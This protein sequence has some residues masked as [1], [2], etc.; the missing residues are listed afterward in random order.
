M[1]SYRVQSKTLADWHYHTGYP[2]EPLSHIITGYH[3]PHRGN[4]CRG[5][6]R[7]A[8]AHCLPGLRAFSWLWEACIDR[9]RGGTPA[10]INHCK[11]VNATAPHSTKEKEAKCLQ[12]PFSFSFCC[13]KPPLPPPPPH[14]HTYIHTF[15]CCC[16]SPSIAFLP[17]SLHPKAAN[18]IISGGMFLEFPVNSVISHLNYLSVPPFF[19]L[20]DWHGAASGQWLPGEERR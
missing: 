4:R 6:K 13:F 17:Y 3:F 1:G 8:Q 18:R 2:T 9:D 10:P 7:K 16:S 14:T 5:R 15:Y 11:C 19:L 12:V 20:N